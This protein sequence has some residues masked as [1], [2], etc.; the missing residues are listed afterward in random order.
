VIVGVQV[1]DSVVSFTQFFTDMVPVGKCSVEG[2]PKIV[3]L[4]FQLMCV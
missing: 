3:N 1:P 4:V 2:G